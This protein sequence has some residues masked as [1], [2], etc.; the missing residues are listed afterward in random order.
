MFYLC[1]AGTSELPVRLPSRYGVFLFSCLLQSSRFLVESDFLA[2]RLRPT[3][4]TICKILF[5]SSSSHLLSSK[6][7]VA[8]TKTS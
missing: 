3:I 4:C 8:V 2:S 7:S 5:T 6:N 1:R